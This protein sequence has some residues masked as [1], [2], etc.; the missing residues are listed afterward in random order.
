MTEL[1]LNLAPR[2]YSLLKIL[3]TNIDSPKPFYTF[4]INGDHLKSIFIIFKRK[5]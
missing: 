1:I 4:L 3:K 2:L 5:C